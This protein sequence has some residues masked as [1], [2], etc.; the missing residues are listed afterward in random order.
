MS[1][2]TQGTANVW[3]YYSSR[4]V[5]RAA[6][7]PQQELGRD[8]F[9][10]ILVSQLRHQDPLQPMQDTEFIAQMAQFSA[11]EQMM[12]VASE[13]RALRQSAGLAAGL[14]GKEVEWIETGQDGSVRRKGV[15]ESIVIRDGE[16]YVRIGDTEVKVGDLVS[17]AEPAKSG[18]GTGDSGE[19]TEGAADSGGL[20][21]ADE[22]PAAGGVPDADG[23]NGDMASGDAGG[24]G[25]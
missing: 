7:T 16:H 23:A 18:S 15:V 2:Y 3:P 17:I 6:R 4:N 13:I 12:N 11:L 8:Q 21:G 9:L 1:G 5:Q 19:E 25:A 20:T 10:Q 14:I 22:D 24:G